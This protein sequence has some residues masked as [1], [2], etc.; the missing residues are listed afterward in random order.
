MTFTNINEVLQNC[1]DDGG[2]V[3]ISLSPHQRCASHTLNLVSCTDIDK[4]LLSRAETKVVYRSATAKC[5]ALWNKASRS[6]VAAETVDDVI[7]K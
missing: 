3:V 1:E 6:T 4:W 5:A 7:A 2:D